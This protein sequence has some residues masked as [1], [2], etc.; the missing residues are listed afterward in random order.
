[1]L[2]VSPLRALGLRTPRLVLRLGDRSELEALARAAER[3]IH[4]PAEMPFAVPWTDAVG[5]PGFVDGFVGFHEQALAE[6]RRD[7]W[8]LNLLAFRGGEPVGTQEIQATRFGTDRVVG[9][10]SWLGR[11]HQGQGLGTEMRA[12]VL[13]LAF[14]RLGA[15]AAESAWIESGAGQSAGVS[16]RLGYVETGTELV[17]PRDEPV[18]RHNLRLARSDWTCPF[19]IELEGVGPCLPLFGATRGRSDG[20]P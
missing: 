15:T 17:H 8:R 9:T 16:A 10:G 13:E 1:M 18:V 5:T 2:D 14:A 4:D 3:G 6:W 11:A 7:F 20:A 12:A 19:A